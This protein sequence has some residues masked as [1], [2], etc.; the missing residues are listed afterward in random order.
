M[1]VMK[2]MDIC[3]TRFFTKQIPLKKKW[4]AGRG[5]EETLVLY[6]YHHLVLV[7]NFKHDQILYQWWER[8]ADKRGLDSAK[9]WLQI[10]KEL[11]KALLDD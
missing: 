9:E 11:T 7:Y 5:D 1:A 8:E 3:L 4:F 6:H 10:H 2:Q